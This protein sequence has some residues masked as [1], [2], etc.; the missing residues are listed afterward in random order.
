MQDSNGE[1][2]IQRISSSS[3]EVQLE[4]IGNDG[5]TCSN[6]RVSPFPF[7]PVPDAKKLAL[8]AGIGGEASPLLLDTVQTSDGVSGVQDRKRRG[9]SLSRRIARF[10]K[11]RG[12]RM[13]TCGQTVHM[14]TC[15]K[16]G[17]GYHRQ[18]FPLRCADPLCPN[19]SRRKAMRLSATLGRGLA[20]Y[21]GKRNLHAYLLTLTFKD[22]DTLPSYSRIVKQSKRLLS[23]KKLWKPYGLVGGVRAFEIKLG[24]RSGLWHPHFHVLIFTRLPIPCYVDKN[25]AVR[26]EWSVNQAISEQ[27]QKITTDSFIV[28][29]RAFDGDHR[30][31]FKYLA[32]GA[33][34]MNDERLREL[35]E[36]QRH[37]RVLSLF[38]ELYNN[39][40]LK[41]AMS[42][43]D[44]EDTP[45]HSCP[46]CGGTLQTVE[47]EWNGVNYV[48]VRIILTGEPPGG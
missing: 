32:K 20:D 47:C 9:V 26:F 43:A 30:E 18:T 48:P 29:G 2:K 31:L 5:G 23:L 8:S 45:L 39:A 41:E 34:K 33:E 16:P 46:E 19:C 4:G 10:D 36:W 44:A 25:E 28:D 12:E 40:E 1:I 22:T 38:G 11:R 24:E 3:A 37:K 35:A 15:T 27:W 7:Q 6:G 21:Q 13:A 17:C 14:T 42:Q